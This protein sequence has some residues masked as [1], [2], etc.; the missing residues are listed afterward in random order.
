MAIGHWRRVRIEFRCSISM[1]TQACSVGFATSALVGRVS[2]LHNPNTAHVPSSNVPA[3]AG[4][5]DFRATSR[6]WAC[7]NMFNGNHLQRCRGN[8][9]TLQSGWITV[10]VA[11]LLCL[12]RQLTARGTLRKPTVCSSR[13]VGFFRVFLVF[14]GLL[15]LS[16][17]RDFERP[18]AVLGVILERES[19]KTLR[20]LWVMA[21]GSG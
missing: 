7:R 18:I 10:R 19:A 5:F 3:K 9:P 14:A 4:F 13:N 1:I 12:V 17:E 2:L 21:S 8:G 16:G 6:N 11:Q 15:G 20:D